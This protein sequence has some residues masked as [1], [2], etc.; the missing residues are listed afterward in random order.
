MALSTRKPL[1]KKSTSAAPRSAAPRSAARPA[2]PPR[3]DLLEALHLAGRESSAATV[4]FHSAIAGRA[5]LAVTDTKTIDTLLRLGPLTAGELATHTGLATA[6]VTALID[7]LERK[8][9]VQRVRDSQDRR[10]VIVKPVQA[11]IEQGSAIFESIRTYYQDLLDPYT[12][13]QLA[14]ILDYIRRATQ[15]TREV[16]ARISHTPP[17]SPMPPP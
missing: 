17:G 12:D 16:T 9:L 14:T 7:R 4:L 6:S 5:G 15:R 8:G 13:D 2:T 11:R 10:R 3:K 1:K